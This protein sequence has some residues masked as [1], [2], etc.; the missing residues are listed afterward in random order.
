LVPTL[1]YIT[2]KY[3]TLLNELTF[4]ELVSIALVI[5]APLLLMYAWLI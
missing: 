4:S 3:I 2:M 1:W 5:T